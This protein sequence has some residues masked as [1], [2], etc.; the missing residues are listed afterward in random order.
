MGTTTNLASPAA[1]LPQTRDVLPSSLSVS[2]EGEALALELLL[3]VKSAACRVE[4]RALGIWVERGGAR[5]GLSGLGTCKGRGRGG[6]A[7]IRVEEVVDLEQ[8]VSGWAEAL[9]EARSGESHL[10]VIDLAIRDEHRVRVVLVDLEDCG[11]AFVYMSCSNL[12]HRK[13]SSTDRWHP[14]PT[15]C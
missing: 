3:V 8:V 5:E 2:L 9:N 10:F 15:R 14:E 1:D 12:K 13:V 4:T 7:G 6:G 11:R